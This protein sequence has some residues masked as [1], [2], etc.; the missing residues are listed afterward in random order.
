MSAFGKVLD[1]ARKGA[2]L[3]LFGVTVVGSVFIVTGTND[4]IKHNRSMAEQIKADQKQQN[5]LLEAK[6]GPHIE[7]PREEE[8]K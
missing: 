2:V 5:A 7:L 6:N 4:V 3:G 8:T 1:F